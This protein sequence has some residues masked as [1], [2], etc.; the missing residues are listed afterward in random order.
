MDKV[1]VFLAY[2]VMSVWYGANAAETLYGIPLKP[3]P[4]FAVDGDLGDWATVPKAIPM[5]Q[6]EQVVWGR[7]AWDSPTDLSGVAHIAWRP[8]HLFVAVAVTDDVLRQ[9]QRGEGIWK[10]DHVELYLDARPELDPHRDTLGEGQS[11]FAFSPGNFGGTG[12]PLTDCVPE[13]FCYL[14]IGLA[15]KEVSVAAQRTATGWTIEAGIPWSILGISQPAEGM[16]LRCEIAISDTDNPEPQQECL[17]T[18]STA[19]WAHTRSRLVAAA[20]A[21]ADGAPKPGKIGRAHV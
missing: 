17:M 1:L 8:D 10:G 11:H 20:L 19:A 21:G 7:G 15:V 16:A 5:A 12:D 14:P 13:A 2:G 4:P 18:T 6:A 3:D 9:T